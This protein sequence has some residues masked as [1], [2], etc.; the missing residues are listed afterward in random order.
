MGSLAVAAVLILVLGTWLKPSQQRAESTVSSA[1]VSSQGERARLDRLAQQGE[2]E[3]TSSFFSQVAFSVASQL[4]RLEL[5]ASGVVWDDAGLIVTAGLSRRFPDVVLADAGGPRA[6]PLVALSAPP[7]LPAA[8][9]R[10]PPGRSLVPVQVVDDPR[11]MAGD[12]AVAVWRTPDRQYS[13]AP[14]L[15]V[16]VTPATCGDYRFDELLLSVPLT[17]TMA[18]GGVFD[19]DGQ[20]LAVILR[21]DDRLVAMAPRSVTATIAECESLEGRLLTRYGLGVSVLHQ[22]E[23]EYF[24]VDSG[25]LVR[26]IWKGYPADAVGI[27]PGDVVTSLDGVEVQA[28]DDLLPLVAAETPTFEV[29][30]IRA[31]QTISMILPGTL[32]RASASDPIIGEGTGRAVQPSAAGFRI[33]W[34]PPASRAE[35]A[36]IRAGDLLLRVDRAVPRDPVAVRQALT[37]DG[38]QP[39]FLI[40]QRGPRVWGVLLESRRN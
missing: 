37:G 20:L 8:I 9:L 29:S 33:E 28:I 17:E 3:R 7:A 21:C 32:V 16:G 25:V 22:A 27:L 6:T 19:L 10:A 5:G 14:G 26:E 38:E 24:E 11:A 40:L 13:F 15:N 18:G 31:N 35:T 23:D 30:V 34:I 39:T 2:L 12:W 4:V 36:G 1:P